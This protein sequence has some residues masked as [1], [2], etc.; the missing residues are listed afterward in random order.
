[1]AKV[2]LASLAP[3][4]DPTWPF[5][6][7]PLNHMRES[8]AADVFGVHQ[9]TDNPDEADLILFIENCDP[10][11][12]YF[13]A[14]NHPYF[15]AHRE[16]CFMY[17]RE[18]WPVP[19]LPG[20][21]TSLS[22]K[23]YDPTRMRAGMYLRVLEDGFITY[24]P[25]F[26]ERDYLY[27]FIGKTNTHPTRPEIMGLNHPRQY[28]MDTTPLW[29]YGDLSDAERKEMEDRYV[30]VGL[31]S[32]FILCPRGIGTS[33]IRLFESLRMG[34][35]PVI[36]ADD[37]VEPDGPDWD[38]FSIRIPERDVTR[39]PEI[40]ESHEPR[41]EVLGLR[42]RQAWVQWFSKQAL[43]HR[44]VEWCLSIMR[45]RR[46]PE[47]HVPLSVVPQLMRPT[48]I[49]CCVRSYLSAQAR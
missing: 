41:A 49:K 38:S 19:F 36:L 39:I 25:D 6:Y 47:R 46:K 15:K 27:S 5:P 45:A 30:E 28:L 16:R 1:M 26:E 4:D 33:S 18:D 8:A 32:K 2:L 17:S 37:W 44:S 35:A 40:L 31:R 34:R 13:E 14:R 10:I 9:T 12:H 43:F 11:R 22:K 48:H 7:D 3:E 20:I 42:A 21:Y 23:W 24:R 29:P